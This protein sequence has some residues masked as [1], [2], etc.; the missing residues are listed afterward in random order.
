VEPPRV[1]DGGRMHG[2]EAERDQ[3]RDADEQ[4][5]IEDA[6]RAVHVAPDGHAF[7][8]D[9]ERAPRSSSRSPIGP[10]G[11]RSGRDG[12]GAGA[13]GGGRRG[14]TAPGGSTGG[15]SSSSITGSGGVSSISASSSGVSSTSG[16]VSGGSLPSR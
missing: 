9:H 16:S 13:G 11:S 2:H 5:R 1:V 14:A 10:V 8:E 6:D 12:D 7:V 3:Q 15:S 4:G